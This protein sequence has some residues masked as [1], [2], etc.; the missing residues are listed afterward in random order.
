ML[1]VRMLQ[2]G[3][4]GDGCNLASTLCLYDLKKGYLFVLG[5]RLRR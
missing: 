1:C 2:R 3:H 4:N 5:R